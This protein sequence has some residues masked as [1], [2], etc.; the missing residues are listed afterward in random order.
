[1]PKLTRVR[2]ASLKKSPPFLG[3]VVFFGLPLHLSHPTCAHMA[4]CFVVSFVVSWVAGGC[5]FTS[6]VLLV[7]A[8][9]FYAISAG[10]TYG[11]YGCRTP[12]V[13]SHFRGLTFFYVY[14]LI[15]EIDNYSNNKKVQQV[16]QFV[17]ASKGQALRVFQKIS[18]P[19][20]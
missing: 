15:K 12:L 16:R 3:R 19:S 14:C 7:F 18:T 13:G 17:T 6:I 11:S 9:T 10:T 20:W 8:L 4:L 1:M 5:S 2:F